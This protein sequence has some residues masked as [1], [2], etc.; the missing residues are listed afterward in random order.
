MNN[1]VHKDPWI[2]LVEAAKKAAVYEAVSVPACLLTVLLL[3]SLSSCQKINPEN[4]K[5]VH[6]DQI[7]MVGHGG[8]GFIRFNQYF[9]IN[10]EEAIRKAIEGYGAHGV[11]LDVQFTSDTVPVLFHSEDLREKSFGYGPVCS[12]PYNEFRKLYFR[13]NINSRGAMN[14]RLIGLERALEIYKSYTDDHLLMLEFKH[15]RYCGQPYQT[16]FSYARAMNSLI[17]AAG[18]RQRVVI[19]S[20]DTELL[21]YVGKLNPNLI[22]IYYSYSYDDALEKVFRHNFHGFVLHHSRV[23]ASEV[24]L[25]QDAGLWVVLFG[26]RSIKET[27][28][29]IR[30]APDIM[31]SD[32]LPVAL[33]FLNQTT[34]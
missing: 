28:E 15:E 19:E 5:P 24:R 17:V 20:K 21:E 23:N 11:E 12:V 31:V 25:A 16:I 13:H 1:G 27:I 14:P 6:F 32:N 10:S 4:Y 30:K 22:L 34:K 7:Q 3:F 33:G 2:S 18:L 26:M 9:P 29:T 8:A